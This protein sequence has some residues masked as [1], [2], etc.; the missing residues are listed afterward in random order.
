MRRNLLKTLTLVG[1]TSGL[2]CAA[3]ASI[4][5]STPVANLR[6]YTGV[7]VRGSATNMLAWQGKEL[8]KRTALYIRNNCQFGNVFTGEANTQATDAIN[9]IIDLSV[10]Q[11]SRG[12]SGIVN[13]PNVAVVDVSMALSDSSSDELLG[14]ASIRGQSPA[15]VTSQAQPE[16]LALDVVARSITQILV[17][18][19]CKGERIARVAPPQPKPEPKPVDAAITPEQVA[20]AEA[21][22]EEGKA[23]FR[24]GDPST[25]KVKFEAAIAAN[26]DPR[27]IMN[28]CLAEEAIGNFDAAIAT[29]QRIVDGKADTRLVEKAQ[30]RIS[31]IGEL[32][33]SN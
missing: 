11:S 3:Q 7:M 4:Q 27:Y 8:A 2:G 26:P 22:S 29:C 21:L 25:A 17:K 6:V 13:N 20:Q 10:L 19:G 32:K 5:R 30:A 14:S 24:E 16:Q 33:S 31:L 15:V 23:A 12:G 28:L 9:L 1:L 18:S